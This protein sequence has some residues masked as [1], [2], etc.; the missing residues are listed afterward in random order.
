MRIVP[1]AMVA[2]A[3]VLAFF[4]CSDISLKGV[5]NQELGLTGGG[6]QGNTSTTI[7][8]L[9]VTNYAAATITAYTI[10][11]SSGALTPVV[12]SPFTTGIQPNQI[13]VDPKGNFLY[14]TFNNNGPGAYV[15]AFAIN[16][17]TGALT[18]IGGQVSTG[19][20]PQGIAVDPTGKFV[21]VANNGNAAMASVSAYT[22]NP[23]TGL[24][25]TAGTSFIS[26]ITATPVGITVDST[27]Q[28][29]YVTDSTHSDV[30]GFSINTSNGTLNPLNAG[31]GT[32][33]DI[34]LLAN[35]PSG[36]AATG[37][38]LYVADQ[39]NNG[40]TTTGVT[41]YQI[42]AGGTLAALAGSPFDTGNVGPTGIVVDPTGKYVYV[43]NNGLLAN[44]PTAN[45]SISAYTITPGTGAL[46]KVGGSPFTTSGGV[47]AGIVIDPTGKF[48]YAS[49]NYTSGPSNSLFAETITTGTG[50]LTSVSGSPFALGVSQPGIAVATLTTP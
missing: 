2:A 44:V 46:V 16:P 5:I 17:S 48:V 18:P 30:F 40:G 38:Y 49:G 22:I 1:K 45:A 33:I 29:V 34:A 15:S 4:G 19:Q 28:Y 3:I 31:L 11:T 7:Y 27:G 9:Y 36:I 23:S 24:L 26:P 41:G 6:T 13:A 21:Y 39:G 42:I 25:S 50:A 32:S 47:P 14:V 20:N 35:T 10:N 37:S 8:V 12:G 43:A